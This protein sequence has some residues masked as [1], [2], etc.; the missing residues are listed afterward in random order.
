MTNNKPN[1]FIAS[2]QEALKFAKA[3]NIR[4]ESIGV[5][6]QWDNAFELSSI[7]ITKLIEKTNNVDYAVF[8]LHGDD[9]SIL[10]D[11]SYNTVRDNVLFELGLFIGKLGLEN[12]FILAPSSLDQ[13]FKFRIPTDLSGITISFYDTAISP[14]DAV[15]ASCAKIEFAIEELEKTKKTI[16]EKSAKP[17]D[18]INRTLNHYQSLLWQSGHEKDSLTRRISELEPL[19]MS[20]LSSKLRTATPREIL[21]WENGAKES[22]LEETKILTRK[23][24]YTNVNML[25][26]PLYGAS[27][28]DIIVEKGC[29]V[30]FVNLGHSTLYYMDGFRKIGL[31]I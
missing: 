3:V 1:I 26:P 10:R 19:I 25:L 11:T 14:V 21:E 5:I 4:L 24:Y 8:V 13:N 27:S 23:V 15:T 16:L 2:S 17:T 18:D 7:T 12:C 20:D 31:H 6:K 29:E 22:Y 28:L 30:K 9:E